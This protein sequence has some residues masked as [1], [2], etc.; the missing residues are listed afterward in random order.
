MSTPCSISP[1]VVT[2][3]QFY[4]Y[5]ALDDWYAGARELHGYEATDTELTSGGIVHFVTDFETD[6]LVWLAYRKIGS[7]TR[8][9]Q[10]SLLTGYAPKIAVPAEYQLYHDGRSYESTTGDVP[11]VWTKGYYTLEFFTDGTYTVTDTEE[12]PNEVTEEGGVAN[13]RRKNLHERVGGL[14]ALGDPVGLTT[15]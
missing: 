13:R 4:A 14:G 9:R 2:V 3:D 15:P 1:A 5:G 8:V 10:T 7:F 11:G 12:I 6:D